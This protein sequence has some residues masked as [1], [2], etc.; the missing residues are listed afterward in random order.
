[1]YLIAFVG[2]IPWRKADS[3]VTCQPSQLS[4]WKTRKILEEF[5]CFPS[6]SVKATKACQGFC[7]V[8]LGVFVVVVVVV[9]VLFLLFWV[10]CFWDRVSQYSPGCPG[11]HSMWVLMATV[12]INSERI[13]SHPTPV[14]LRRKVPSMMLR[15]TKGKRRAFVCLFFLWIALN[16]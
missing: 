4:D 12:S 13:P 1:M 6:Y 14:Q 16:D 8:G 10:F 5:T 7:L 2:E 11:A 15:A 3:R 9:T